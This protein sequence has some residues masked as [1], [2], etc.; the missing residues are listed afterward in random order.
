MFY[1]NI[2]IQSRKINRNNYLKS[3][4]IAIIYLVIGMLFCA[5]PF[6]IKFVFESTGLYSS[7]NSVSNN[8]SSILICV[9]LS[10]T[11]FMAILFYSSATMG[12]KAWYSGR[13]ENKKRCYKRI[14]YWFKI[15]S[16]FKACRLNL[17]LVSIKVL[18]SI[19]F[20][21]PAIIT[22]TTA[23]ALAFS[24]GVEVYLFTALFF[25]SIVLFVIGFAF[26]LIMF[27]KYFLAPYLL[28]ENPKLGIWQVIKQSKNLAEGHI[29]TLAFFKMLFLPTFLLYPLILPAIFLYPHYKQCCCVIAKDLRV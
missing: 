2:R 21:S 24:G 17:A 29:F 10:V 8:L 5:T 15:K 1:K 13:M 27:Q 9:L 23:V 11:T 26:C 18:W 22:L 16:S 25:G 6:L 28:A 4:S 7:L 3:F 12:E 19:L 20:L 14:V